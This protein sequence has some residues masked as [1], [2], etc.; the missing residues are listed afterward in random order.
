MWRSGRRL[1]QLEKEVAAAR[2]ERA[3][4]RRRLQVFE[5]IAAAAGRGAGRGLAAGAETGS[6]AAGPATSA[7]ATDA[8]AGGSH[9]APATDPAPGLPPAAP[10]PPELLAAGRELRAHGVPV[11]LDVDGS[12]FVAVIEGPGDPARWWQAIREISVEEE[13]P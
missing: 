13:Q 9:A 8:A 3:E 2:A 4:L 12:E 10:V 11:R 5:D 7:T 6:S 1:R